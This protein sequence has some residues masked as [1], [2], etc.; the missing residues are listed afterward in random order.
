MDSLQNFFS[1]NSLFYGM[2][3][4]T[5][6]TPQIRN[7]NIFFYF[8]NISKALKIMCNNHS[9]NLLQT[10]TGFCV[11]WKRNSV[12]H[13]GMI[14]LTIE[15]VYFAFNKILVLRTKE[16]VPQLFPACLFFCLHFW[17]SPKGMQIN[18]A[19]RQQERKIISSGH[20]RSHWK[21]RK[22]ED[23]QTV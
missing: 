20:V 23:S 1:V 14:E 3:S 13:N 8:M 18:M 19:V 22:M 17:F 6:C 11:A 4:V 21:E 15:P 10:F 2:N 7:G 16:V 9:I 5:T 12:V